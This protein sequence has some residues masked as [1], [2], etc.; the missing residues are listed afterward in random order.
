MSRFYVVYDSG[1]GGVWAV[2]QGPTREAIVERF[3]ELEVVTEPP[4]WMSRDMSDRLEAKV[5]DLDHPTGLLDDI[6]RSRV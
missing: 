4:K 3:P 6:L 1:Q 5:I 2:V